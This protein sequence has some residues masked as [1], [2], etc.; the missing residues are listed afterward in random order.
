MIVETEE[1]KAILKRCTPFLHLLA[2]FKCIDGSGRDEGCDSLMY[3]G[4]QTQP[5][6]QLKRQPSQAR[7]LS[8]TPKQLSVCARLAPSYTNQVVIT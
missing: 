8:L 6:A 4:A 2:A 7:R 5:A 1:E 3:A